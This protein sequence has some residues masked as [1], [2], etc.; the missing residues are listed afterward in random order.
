MPKAKPAL[1]T[2]PPYPLPAHEVTFIKDTVKRF[3][4]DAII[5]S[6]GPEKNE[7]HLHIETSSEIGMEFHDCIGI[8]MA[9]IPRERIAVCATQRGRRPRAQEKIAYRQ[10]EII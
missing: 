10:G 4:G 1:E 8:L 9:E 2:V 3:Y 6:F 7:L 5:R